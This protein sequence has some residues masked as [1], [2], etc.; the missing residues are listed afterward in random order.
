M[1][2]ICL[3]A[4]AGLLLAGAFR[5]MLLPLRLGWKLL[6]G[7]IGGLIVL[8]LV[9]LTAGLTGFSIPINPLTALIA[10]TLGI[11]GLV[12]LALLQLFL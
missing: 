11:P 5:L 6:L 12:L 10:G 2:T 3:L 7:G 1:E 4:I 8:W 9:G